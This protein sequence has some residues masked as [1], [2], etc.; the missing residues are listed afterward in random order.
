VVAARQAVVVVAEAVLVRRVVEVARVPVRREAEVV[1][2]RLLLLRAVV[3]LLLL[4]RRRPVRRLRVVAA[5]LKPVPVAV[6]PAGVEVAAAEAEADR[7]WQVVVFGPVPQYPA[8]RS[9]MRCLQRAPIRMWRSV[10]VV[11][12]P[13]PAVGSAIRC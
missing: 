12:K 2:V 7:L 1:R 9:S 10:R 13:V 3:P 6:V 11:R 4:F 8:W 5:E